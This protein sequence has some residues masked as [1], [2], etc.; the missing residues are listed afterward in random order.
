MHGFATD[1][2]RVLLERPLHLV[3]NDQGL[4]GLGPR[5]SLVEIGC[6][7]GVEFAHL[8]IAPDQLALEQRE[9]GGGDG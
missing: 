1:V 4:D 7:D 2:G 3:L 8:A 5:D 9:H 6:D